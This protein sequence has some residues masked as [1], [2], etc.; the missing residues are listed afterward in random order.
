MGHLGRLRMLYGFDR[1]RHHAVV[2][3]DHQDHDVRHLRASSAH[4][5]EGRMT[6]G[7]EEGHHALGGL[8]VVGADVLSNAARLAGRD[9]GAADVIEQ[10][11]LA[12]I[13][14]SHHGHDRRARQHLERGVRLALQVVLDDVFLAQHRRV[15]HFLDHQH[16]GVLLDHLI[17]RRHHAHVHHDLDDFGG[18]DRHFLRQLA[19]RHGLADRHLAHHPR[20]RHLESVLAYRHR[21]HGTAAPVA[22]LLL[23]VARAHVADDVQFLPAVAGGLVVHLDARGLARLGR[24]GLALA[25]GYFTRLHFGHAARLFL[26]SP[27][28]VL[29]VAAAPALLLQALAVEALLL[30]PLVLGLFDG[31]PRLLL[32]LALP[33]E[34]FLLVARLIFEHLALDV[35]ALAAHL[36]V[37]GA[38]AAL[39]ARELQFRL[40]FAPQGD[41]ARSR[42]GLH[43]VV[44]VAAPQVRQ[45]LVLRILA[46][47]VLG[48]LDPDSRLIELL[49]QPIDRHFQHLGELGDGNVCH[50]CS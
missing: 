24:G 20:S 32:A 5:C 4:G 13:D 44:A 14:V 11:G 45:Q 21:C 12:V 22:G 7:I 48:A 34:L 38:R 33:V 10:R 30:E 15:A 37:D 49:Q 19:D 42:V 26:G 29:L 39:R 46:D 40:R 47:H 18:L 2:G 3:A 43:V 17:D 28:A 50:T 41:L 16:C 27:L 1:L 35:G 36:D 23:L 8:Y 9:L 6:R 25:L 31:G